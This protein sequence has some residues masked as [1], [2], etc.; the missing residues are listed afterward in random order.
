MSLTA[1]DRRLK[2]GLFT[3]SDSAVIEVLE[4]TGEDDEQ[5]LTLGYKPEFRRDFTLLGLFSFASSQLAV[6]PGVA[7][8]IWCVRQ[9]DLIH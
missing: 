6:L 1:E 5:L 7:G 8:T 9:L 2:I 4:V 3:P